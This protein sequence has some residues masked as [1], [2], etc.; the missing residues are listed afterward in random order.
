MSVWGLFLLGYDHDHD[1]LSMVIFFNI[2]HNY[3]KSFTSEGQQ[4]GWLSGLGPWLTTNSV[5]P[6]YEWVFQ[7]VFI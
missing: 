7:F 6:N 2:I 3:F 4:S 1:A 5:G